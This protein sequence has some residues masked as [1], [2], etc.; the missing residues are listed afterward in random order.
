M[1]QPANHYSEIL[2]RI[3][4]RL[5]RSLVT[6]LVV[7]LAAGGIGFATAVSGASALR[8]WQIF[9]VNF[10]FWS[11]IAQAGVAFS[12]ILH[13]TNARWG[14]P[15]QRMAEATA[16]FLPVS[17][18]LFLALYF[19]REQ[20]FPWIS[21]PVPEKA[22]WLNLPFLFARDGI[23][24][25]MLYGLSLL[26]LY[27]SLRPDVGL[28]RGRQGGN[29]GALHRALTAG[30]RGLE[31]ERRRSRRALAV[32][33]PILLILYAVVFSLIGFDLVMSLDP[34]WHSALFGGYFFVGNLY[35]GLATLALVA[36]LAR[37]YL[38]LE[39]YVTPSHFHDVGKLV[40][41]F[42]LLWTYLFWA[43]YLPIWY[44]NLPEETEF[45]LARVRGLWSP[46]A[47]SVLALCF[48]IPFVVL[49]SRQVKRRPGTLFAIS[50]VVVAGMW[51]ERYVLVVPSLWT[52]DW[53][54][55][56][57][58]E[59]LITLGFLAG[60]VLCYLAFLFAFPPLP[61]AELEPLSTSR[62]QTHS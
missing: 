9:L 47:W 60:A 48:A 11:G 44:G 56:G 10:L 14:R 39:A 61:L 17:F 4:E 18:L 12:A 54:P 16:S 5:L 41:A 38:R 33:S 32:L 26:F 27:Y 7:L 30:W 46:W 53:V 21:H 29:P 31:Q 50:A 2:G 49:L 42:C 36:V 55:L 62:E 24:L 37:R 57:G 6:L 8:A 45:V 59:V 34:H 35:L 40:F 13:V 28:I 1:N 15:L 52:E 3:P 20:L 19:G 51:L 25:L 58:L 43:H 22:A 23:G